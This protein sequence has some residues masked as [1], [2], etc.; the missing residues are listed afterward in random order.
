MQHSQLHKMVDQIVCSIVSYTKWYTRQYVVQSATQNGR[1]DSM[2][3]SQLHRMV[4]QVVCSV[5]SQRMVDQ[6]VST[7]YSKLHR[8]VD[9]IACSIVSYSRLDSMYKSVSKI[10]LLF[11]KCICTCSNVAY[12]IYIVMLVYYEHHTNYKCTYKVHQ[13]SILPVYKKLKQHHK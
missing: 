13:S 12:F 1:L 4:Y 11:S 9:Q 10:I 6:V 3:Y 8:M 7:Q 2:Q 5:V